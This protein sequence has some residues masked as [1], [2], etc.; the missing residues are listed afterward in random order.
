MSRP[1]LP[2]EWCQRLKESVTVVSA[3]VHNRSRLEILTI[4]ARWHRRLGDRLARPSYSPRRFG[5]MGAEMSGHICTRHRT[6]FSRRARRRGPSH[7]L[8]AYRSVPTFQNQIERAEK[9]KRKRSARDIHEEKKHRT[10]FS[11]RVRRRRPP[12]MPR[13]HRRASMVRVGSGRAARV[14]AVMIGWHVGTK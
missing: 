5:T 6:R 10:K 7:M 14:V 9:V 13:A 1:S 2:R 11:G 3:A 8:Q 4:F 12:N